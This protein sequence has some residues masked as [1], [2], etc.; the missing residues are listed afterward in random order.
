[1]KAEQHRFAEQTFTKPTF[2]GHCKQLLWG[3]R[4][5]GLQCQVCGMTA[6]R[7]RCDAILQQAGCRA[8]AAATKKDVELILSA[9]ADDLSSSTSG[10][11]GHDFVVTTFTA[12]TFCAVCNAFL[13]GLAKQGLRCSCCRRAVHKRCRRRAARLECGDVEA[14]NS[15]IAGDEKKVVLDNELI[16]TL[17]SEG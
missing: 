7:K 16:E 14:G 10:A 17:R 1:M 4:N 15:S 2:C 12:P 13:W 11:A 3:L 6:H 9:S 5:Q 8:A